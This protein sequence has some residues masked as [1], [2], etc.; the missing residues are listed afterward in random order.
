MAEIRR[1]RRN[2]PPGRTI[3][4]FVIGVIAVPSMVSRVWFALFGGAAIGVQRSGID[5]AGRDLRTDP[6]IVGARA[7]VP[8][9][10]D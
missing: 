1:P 2:D 7:P 3:R 6:M 4:R 9:A 5:L 10:G 8:S